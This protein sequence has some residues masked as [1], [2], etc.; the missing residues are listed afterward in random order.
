[1]RFVIILVGG[2][3]LGCTAF[4]RFL[5]VRTFPFRGVVIEDRRVGMVEGFLRYLEFTTRRF[6][7][8]ARWL[9]NFLAFGADLRNSPHWRGGD[10][11]L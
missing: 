7:T 8:A 4:F 6:P 2:V 9:E 10:H 3:L 5:G 1:M 11:D